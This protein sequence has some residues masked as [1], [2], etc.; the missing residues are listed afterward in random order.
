[1]STLRTRIR[2]VLSLA[3]AALIF[4]ATVLGTGVATAAP[5][6]SPSS[7]GESVP[8]KLLL[9]LDASGSMLEA[10]PS[11][12]TRMEAAKKG[13]TAVVD[14]LPDAAQVGLR[15]YGATVQGGTPT[16]EACA[17]TQLVSP[18]K[19]LDKAALR[20][21]I[22]GFQAK[23]ETPIAHSLQKAI[24]DLG[25]TGKRNIV[26]VSDGEESCVPD[27][28]PVIKE[29]IGAGIDLQIDTV[30]YAVGDKARQQLQCIADAG[31]GTYYDAAN[32]DQIAASL[33][34]LSTRASREFAVNG[35]PID[36][37][38][39]EAGAPTL[40]AGLWVDTMTTG[41]KK[42]YILKRTIPGSTMRVAVSAR[43]PIS[44]T[45]YNIETIRFD[46]VPSVNGEVTSTSGGCGALPGM[47]RRVGGS[48]L[49]YLISDAIALAG[50]TAAQPE[51]CGGASLPFW[52]SR[53]EGGPV[54]LKVEILVIEEPPLVSPEPTASPQP[55]V[56]ST[57]S[58]PE[59]PQPVTGGSSFSD[60]PLIGAGSWTEQFV[61]Q[62]TILYRVRVDWGQSL[63]VTVMSPKTS[64]LG[65]IYDAVI[66]SP[67]RKQ[68]AIGS[69]G[70]TR[71]VG[72]APLSRA[73]A[74]V[75][76]SNR[77][78]EFE[79]QPSS[80]AG[81]Y[82]LSISMPDAYQDEGKGVLFP[83]TFRVDVE[84]SPQAAPN[85]AKPVAAS[86]AASA[87]PSANAS[88]TAAPTAAG[89]KASSN[90]SSAL[91]LVG[92]G[93]LALAVLGGIGYAVWRRRAQ[94]ATQA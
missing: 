12:L 33:S 66:Y 77:V 41:A 56:T 75:M 20:N 69:S 42:H 55:K 14:K 73:I 72:I 60:A 32:A 8:G 54:P 5:S 59:N 23:G 24:E 65:P 68:A 10:D 74:P 17:D 15:V 84:G 90:D 6:P 36:G 1:M 57:P 61:P 81:D 78:G 45:V 51:K 67:D 4:G 52:I 40:S 19:A 80:I 39:A 29:L 27:P 43:P 2:A 28:C 64:L 76:Y 18:I 70:H 46:G 88:D 49:R 53:D 37:T 62:E 50:S 71:D 94:G 22:A 35:T 63:R 83:V 16:P 85:Y 11:G 93:L 44:D 9:M 31:H 86:P 92:G 48:D 38:P 25:P 58:V 7:P 87:S 21:A 13:L 30:G 47:A 26:L 89:E 34:K 79:N 3:G 82:Y 91:P